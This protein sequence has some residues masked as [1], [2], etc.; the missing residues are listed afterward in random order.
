[1]GTLPPALEII[2]DGLCLSKWN[3]LHRESPTP[4]V[5]HSCSFIDCC[6]DILTVQIEVIL[7]DVKT[8]LIHADHADDITT[9]VHRGDLTTIAFPQTGYKCPLTCDFCR[10]SLSALKVAQTHAYMISFPGGPTR[11]VQPS[12]RRQMLRETGHP[13]LVRK[14]GSSTRYVL[15]WLFQAARLRFLD[16]HHSIF[17]LKIGELYAHMHDV[18]ERDWIVMKKQPGQWLTKTTQYKNLAP[19]VATCRKFFQDVY[20]AVYLNARN[21]L[22]QFG[23]AHAG[24]TEMNEA[25]ILLEFDGAN[26]VRTSFL[27]LSGFLT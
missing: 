25:N 1:M 10:T 13:S 8:D 22:A 2:Q 5:L 12:V 27:L 16:S 15:V 7:G 9:T 20:T 18:M 3:I 6:P 19:K 23:C 11:P 17:Y 26:H 24:K 4:D 14:L 21:Y